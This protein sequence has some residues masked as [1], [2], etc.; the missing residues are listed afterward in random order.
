LCYFDAVQAVYLDGTMW[1]GLISSIDDQ[2]VANVIG[3]WAFFW[4][5]FQEWKNSKGDTPAQTHNTH[6]FAGITWTETAITVIS[7]LEF[8]QHRFE[9]HPG[10]QVSPSRIS[11]SAL[12][13]IFGYI[14][15][16]RAGDTTCESVR[17][18]VAAIGL[19]NE[20]E[21][22]QFESEYLGLRLEALPLLPTK[23]S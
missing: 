4:E 17:R 8:L 15:S 9:K 1:R 11:Q 18:G 12:E 3:G 22:L 10:S 7:F 13:G 2:P 23:Q 21:Y 6:F 14:R 19:L 20:N 16:F 5:W